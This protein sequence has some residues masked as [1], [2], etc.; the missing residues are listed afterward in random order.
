[1]PNSKRLYREIL[2]KIDQ[3]ILN[4][5]IESKVAK[6]ISQ[7]MND[8]ELL[9]EFTRQMRSLKINKLKMVKEI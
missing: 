2:N 9:A 8:P 1:M 3:D 5:T 7:L 4:D 6:L